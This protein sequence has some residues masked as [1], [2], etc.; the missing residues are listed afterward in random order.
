MPLNGPRAEEEPRA[1]LRIGQPI[2][3]EP[4]D[5]PLLGGQIVARVDRPL[6]HL[7]ARRLKLLT[8]AL[9]ERLHPDRG[10]HLVG[11][12]QLLAR[13]DPAILAAQ[14][15]AVEEVRA[16]ELR[17]EPGAPQPLDRLAIQLVGG[18]PVAQQ[19]P[20]ARLDAER[21]LGAAGLCRLGQPLERVTGELGLPSA[22]GRLDQLGQHPHETTS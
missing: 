11:R 13:V 8:R 22:H 21:E 4:R 18:R 12:A 20:A 1:D 19:R 15:L 17:T 3:G 6:A 9:G 16:G 7:L 10:Q 14:P 5:L 2:A